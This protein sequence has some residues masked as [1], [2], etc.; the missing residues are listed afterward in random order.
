LVDQRL[1]LTLELAFAHA[2]FRT[3][4]VQIKIF[5]RHIRLHDFFQPL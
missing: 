3:Q 1:Q 2:G 4:G 5:L